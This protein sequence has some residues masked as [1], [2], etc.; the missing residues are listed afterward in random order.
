MKSILFVIPWKASAINCTDYD[1]S[2]SPERAPENVVSLAT[3]LRHQG[4]CVEIADLNR[5]LVACKGNVNDCL[6]LLRQQCLRFRPDIIGV[7]FFTARFEFAADITTYLRS[8]FTGET[9][10]II[11]GG[12]HPTLLP[13]ITYEYIHFDALIIGEGEL[14]LTAILKGEPLSQIKGVFLPDQ[15]KTESADIIKDLDCLPF[16][17]WSLL[18][19]EFYAQPSYLISYT[20]LHKVMPVTFSRGCMYRCN[21]CAHNCFLSARCHSPEYFVEMMRTTSEQC[22]VDSFIIQDSS[23]GNFKK[24]WSA[25]CERLIAS[26][27]RYNWWANLR[28]N[29]IDE[30]FLCLIKQAGCTKVFLGFESGSQRILDRMNKRITT[31]Q[32]YKAAEL[33]HKL[34]L[35]F[36]SSY[37]VNY[38][39][40]EE[41]DL[42]LTEEMILRTRPTSLAINKFSPIPGSVD[43][44]SNEGLI[45]P[46]LTSIHSWTTLGM[47]LSPIL[48]GNMPPER[49]DYWYKHLR[50]LKNKINNY[51]DH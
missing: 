47:L 20:E 18:D 40:E 16:P 39:G 6:S 12:V 4:A 51:E 11:A 34:D 13:A 31:G 45:K 46:Y 43:Y 42:R 19:K 9:P 28:V 3:Y 8:I 29:Q 26:K 48:F 38:F 32:C 35:P 21:F 14:P 15:K 36:Y 33:C 24:E 25:V 44:D 30:D 17:D 5:L 37:I 23:I 50:A 1:F 49:F 2:Q 22:G 41:E 7:S 27:A 10:L